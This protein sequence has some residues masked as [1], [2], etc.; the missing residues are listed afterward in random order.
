[1]HQSQLNLMKHTCKN[2]NS[3]LTICVNFF[4]SL[5]FNVQNFNNVHEPL[6]AFQ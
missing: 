6:Y 3:T 5:I 4:P 1:M 2:P